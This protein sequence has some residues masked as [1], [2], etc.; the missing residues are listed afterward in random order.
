MGLVADLVPMG[1]VADLVSI[2]AARHAP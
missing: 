2:I 1:L